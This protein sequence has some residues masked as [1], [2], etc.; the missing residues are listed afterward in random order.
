MVT[1]SLYKFIQSELIKRGYNEFTD[2]DGNLVYFDE[3]HQFMTKILSYDRQVSEIINDLFN[4]ISLENDD[5]D[6]HFKKSF[7]YRFVNRYINRQTIESFKLELLSTFL[8]NQDYINRVYTDLDL[9]INQKSIN[10][11][12]NT[13]NNN[14][15]VNGTTISDNRNAFANLPQS[16]VNLDVN[17]TVM[18]YPSD[19]TISRNKQSNENQT[20]GESSGI[21]NSESKSY[22]LDELFKSN[23]IL[24]RIFDKFDKKCFLQVW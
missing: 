15:K 20:V 10:E 2:I 23:D 12:S 14:Q 13:Q 22:Q 19:N 18:Q 11:S 7:L 1:T 17:N 8:V 24:E 5:Y 9:Y 3:D 16:T 21:N 4:G 6:D